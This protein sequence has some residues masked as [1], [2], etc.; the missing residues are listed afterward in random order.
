MNCH[1]DTIEREMIRQK[2]NNANKESQLEQKEKHLK[3]VE[4]HLNTTHAR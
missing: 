4:K 2:R 1:Y 3:L